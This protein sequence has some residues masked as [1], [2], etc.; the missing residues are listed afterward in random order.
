[1]LAWGCFNLSVKASF[2]F[3][4][5]RM[6][7]GDWVESIASRFIEELPEKNEKRNE[8]REQNVEDFIFNQDI[9]YDQGVR[10]PG[11]ARLQKKKLK[12]IK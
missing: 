2:S 10:S 8:L 12:R 3:V 11:W 7:R 9:D 6:Y 1:M 4:M 5:S